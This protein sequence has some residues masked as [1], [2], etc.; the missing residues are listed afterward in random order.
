[1]GLDASK[2]QR[3]VLQLEGFPQQRASHPVLSRCP[4]LRDLHA[5]HVIKCARGAHVSWF[6]GVFNGRW[7]GGACLCTL[8]GRQITCDWCER[9]TATA[10]TRH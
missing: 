7:C 10:H 8:D 3:R 6:S 2:V 9:E 1:M 4:Y 5:L